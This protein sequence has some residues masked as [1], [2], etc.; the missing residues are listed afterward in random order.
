MEYLLII[1]IYLIIKKLKSEAK[2]LVFDV[3]GVCRP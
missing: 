1:K 2:K 3:Y